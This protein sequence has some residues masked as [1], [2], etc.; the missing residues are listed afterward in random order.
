LVLKVNTP[1][2][3]GRTAI[4]TGG[5]RGIGLATAAALHR[6]GAN[7]VITSRS[8]QAAAEAAAS[9]SE[10]VMGVGA[11]ATDQEAAAAC[12]DRAVNAFGGV[13]ILVNNAGTNPAYGAV[14]DQDYGRFAKTFDINLWAPILWSKLVFER[15]LAQHGGSIVNT[16][17][18]GGMSV[19]PNLGIYDVSK[20]A[21]IHL[22]RQL[23]VELAPSVRV[24]AVA[25]G[26]VRTR[27]ASRLWSEDESLVAQLT[28]SGRIG[29][30]ADIAE[31][32]VFLAS[33]SAA[34]I[35]GETLVIDG[36]RMVGATAGADRAVGLGYAR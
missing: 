29:E 2:L 20:A 9:I 33:D 25:P 4:V 8:E 14:L 28:P 1:A 27:L 30:P 10:D 24:N 17:S 19:S 16:A 6:A 13:D 36:G 34:W 31:A 15:S 32:I 23:A 18:V 7:V 26:V 5:S 3:A 22:T 11:H 12:V 21:L 35:T